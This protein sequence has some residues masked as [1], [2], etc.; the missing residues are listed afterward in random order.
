[1]TVHPKIELLL[2]T[3]EFTSSKKRRNWALCN[4][5]F[6]HISKFILAGLGQ[7][8]SNLFAG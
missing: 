3:V 4:L 2:R 7:W 8:I 6:L 5:N 1:V